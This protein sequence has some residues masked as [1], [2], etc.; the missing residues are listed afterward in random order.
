MVRYPNVPSHAFVIVPCTARFGVRVVIENG[1]DVCPF[2]VAVSF[3]SPTAELNAV[4]ELRTVICDPVNDETV[5]LFARAVMFHEVEED[6][7][8]AVSWR[9]VVYPETVRLLKYQTVF[10]PLIVGMTE[11]EL[12]APGTK[13]GCTGQDGRLY[14]QK[15]GV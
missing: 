2:T 12:W 6:P 13:P 15:L 5:M 9:E 7:P 10:W 3:V 14:P 8:L 4:P 1:A 11:P